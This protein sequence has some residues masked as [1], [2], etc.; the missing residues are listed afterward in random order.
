MT[1]RLTDASEVDAC[2][3]VRN[4]GEWYRHVGMR[5]CYNQMVWSIVPE[6]MTKPKLSIAAAITI[7]CYL[8]ARLIACI[9]SVSV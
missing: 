3:T 6:E 8:I 2:H 4:D 5:N 1:L 9:E 7:A